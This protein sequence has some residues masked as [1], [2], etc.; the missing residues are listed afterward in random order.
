MPQYSSYDQV[1][2][3]EDVSDVISNIS[4]TKTP[5]QSMIGSEDVHNTLFQWQEDS[6]RDAAENAKVEGFTA[7]ATERT[8]TTMR[9]NYTQI[10]SETFSVSGTADKV[11][12]YGRAKE[13]AYQAA[14]VAKVLKRD[15]EYA[16]IGANQTAVAGNSA[17]ARKMAGYQAQIDSGNIVDT[18]ASNTKPTETHY[19][20]VLQSCYDEGAEPSIT[21][22]PP[23]NAKHFADY[24]TGTGRSR[25]IGN[26]SKIVNKID[27]YIS[28][29][30][31]QKLVL[32]RHCRTIDTLIFEPDMWKKATLRN[33]FRETLAKTGDALSMM[34]V[35]EF[36]LK[37]KNQK[38]SGLIRQ[39]A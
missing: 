19:L 9:T 21:M 35:G 15:L 25:D 1:G 12:T 34:M 36:S 7:T 22:I 28:P 6:L 18:G 11:T 20:T 13:S 3:K 14:K 30:G 27:V 16:F 24:A 23:V 33:W 10:L 37:H 39:Q 29:F 32:N 26:G 17:T 4:P 38:G 5:F 31:D 8:P 2:K